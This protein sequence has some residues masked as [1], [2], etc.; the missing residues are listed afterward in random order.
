M[1]A[2]G[3]GRIR[4][5][6]V[7]RRAAL[8]SPRRASWL[9]HRFLLFLSSSLIVIVP[10]SHR[11][12]ASAKC[13]IVSCRPL[14]APPS[15]PLVMPV[16][17]C[18]ASSCPLSLRCPLVLVSLVAPAGCCVA[19]QRATLSLSRCLVVSSS[20]RDALS[21]SHHASWLLH[22][23]SSSSRCAALLSFHCAGWLL[24]CLFLR[25]PLVLWLCRPFL[26]RHHLAVVHCQLH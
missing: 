4:G 3:P 18:I 24:R 15:C 20:C 8:L 7:S 25:R 21:S 26:P 6:V 19:S 23:L 14:V 2:F 17:C 5:C 12:V 1:I 11:L 16:C 13:H 22:H 10:P 9:S